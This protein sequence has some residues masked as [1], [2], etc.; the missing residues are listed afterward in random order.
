MNP[1][2]AEI[3]RGMPRNVSAATPPVSASGTPVKTIAA[4][5]AELNA[6][7]SNPKIISSVTGTTTDSRLD[8]DISCSKVPP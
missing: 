7:N 3:D 6:M 2:A 5:L 1:T 4:S 8:A